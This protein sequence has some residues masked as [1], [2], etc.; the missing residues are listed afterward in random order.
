MVLGKQNVTAACPKDKLEF[1]FFLS[2]EFINVWIFGRCTCRSECYF[3]QFRLLENH[4]F[5]VKSHFLIPYFL[6][7]RDN[8]NK[9][10]AFL[11]QLKTEILPLISHTSTMWAETTFPWYILAYKKVASSNNYPIF[12]HL[13]ASFIIR[14]MSIRKWHI[15]GNYFCF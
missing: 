6:E 4:K 1:K 14:F 7:C 15:N 10:F 2:P 5:T 8:S 13:S 3:E 11:P 9:K 12:H